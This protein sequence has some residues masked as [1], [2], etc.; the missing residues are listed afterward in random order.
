VL[1]RFLEYSIATPDIAA[2]LEFYGK[3]GFSQAEA[4]D[5]WPHRYAVV[6]D[7]RLCLGLHDPGDEEPALTFVKPGLL[8]QLEALEALGVDFEFTRLGN[9]VFNELGWLDPCG[10]RIRLV[11]ART[12]SPAKR[13]ATDTSRCGYFLEIGL[14]APDLELAK[15]WWERL[16]FVGMDE[17]GAPLPHISCTSDSIDIGLYD[18]AHLTVPAL[19]FETADVAGALAHLAASGVVPAGR[20]PA[21]LVR[22]AAL[23]TAPEGTQILLL[24]QP[25][26]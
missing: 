15:A 25:D 5:A 7:G 10:H 18:P 4:G 11:E 21:P 12:F 17:P 14:P 20:L 9:D 3:L 19:L 13:L 23:L 8:G 16:G 2:S 22:K 26:G 6:T 24:P 1:G